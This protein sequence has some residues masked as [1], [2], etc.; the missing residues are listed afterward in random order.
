MSEPNV[1]KFKSIDGLVHIY[2]DR[3][4]VQF[5]PHSDVQKLQAIEEYVQ[6]HKV[7]IGYPHYDRL[8]EILLSG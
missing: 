3:M 6:S 1:F 5:S 7:S 4:W 2:L 8:I